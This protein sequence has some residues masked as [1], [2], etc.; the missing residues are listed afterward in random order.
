MNAAANQIAFCW[1]LRA[2]VGFLIDRPDLCASPRSL[3][4]ACQDWTE[5][6]IKRLRQVPIGSVD[7]KKEFEFAGQCAAKD[8]AMPAP[9]QFISH[10]INPEDLQ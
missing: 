4:M 8:V 2:A 3:L 6:T 7:M 9:R 10:L 1:T 5:I